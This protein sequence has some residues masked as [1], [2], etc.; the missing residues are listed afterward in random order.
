[1]RA[2]FFSDNNEWRTGWRMVV[3]VMLIVALGT[4][5]NIGWRALG[6]PRIRVDGVTQ[7]FP[8]LALAS[9]VAG[10]SLLIAAVLRYY[11]KKT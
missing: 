4:A 11:K 9:L 3:F 10:G 7:P 1:M 8:L 6:L 5:V 2:V